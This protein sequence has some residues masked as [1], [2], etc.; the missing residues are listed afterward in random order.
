LSH[1]RDGDK[2]EAANEPWKQQVVIIAGRFGKDKNGFAIVVSC[3]FGTDMLYARMCLYMA[4]F[5]P[6]QCW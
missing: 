4:H 6:L 3:Q 1:S 2:S 5:D